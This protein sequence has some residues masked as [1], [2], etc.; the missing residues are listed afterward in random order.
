MKE[1]EKVTLD[2][3]TYKVEDL[4][5]KVKELMPTD[6]SDDTLGMDYGNITPI[7]VKAIQEQQAQIE[8]L[9]SEINTLKGG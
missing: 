2:G 7:L 1:I 9:Q 4:T 5:V 3:V 8:A 6:D